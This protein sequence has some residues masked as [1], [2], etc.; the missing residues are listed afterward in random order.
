LPFPDKSW[1]RASRSCRRAA[2]PSRSSAS[3]TT[4]TWAQQNGATARALRKTSHAGTRSSGARVTPQADGRHPLRWRTADARRRPGAY[5]S[6]AASVVRR[7]E[8]RPRP[9]D[10]ARGLQRPAACQHR[11]AD[12]HADRRAERRDR[13]R[14]ASRAYLL[15]AGEVVS[16]G[17]AESLR[18]SDAVRRAY[19]GY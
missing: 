7:A 19:L 9:P 3:T 16:E 5:E 15:E 11:A 2:A 6:A 12:G 4:S 18:E 10:R 14:I 8:P 13:P 1:R 17:T